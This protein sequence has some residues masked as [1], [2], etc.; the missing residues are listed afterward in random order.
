MSAAVLDLPESPDTRLV[1][2]VGGSTL[3]VMECGLDG[4]ALRTERYARP[5]ERFADLSAG[6]EAFLLALSHRPAVGVVGA[7]GPIIG[8]RAVRLTNV[9]T[10]PEFRVTEAR[11][12]LGI[13]FHLYNDLV[14]AA[15]AVPVL[16]AGDLELMREGAPS[17]DGPVLVSTI[18]TGLND[19]LVLPSRLGVDR[20]VACESGHTPF[21]P[22][23]HDEVRLLEWAWGQ[24]GVDFLSYELVLSGG[25]GFRLLYDFVVATSGCRSSAVTESELASGKAAAIAI[26]DAVV[27]GGDP[28]C[29]RVA[30]LFG[31]IAGTFIGSRTVATVA[32]GGVYLVGGV[33]HDAPFM[34]HVISKTP[35]LERFAAQG[36]QTSFVA[37]VPIYRV[38]HANP[39]LVGAAEVARQLRPQ[40]APAGAD[41]LRH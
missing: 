23:D 33:T 22:R 31:A 34:H 17:V 13:D 40:R 26:S 14:V 19:A 1:V 2:D 28:A 38:T 20:Y 35:F 9:P 18:S 39:G 30:E 10:W 36:A 8:G 15:A 6:L 24:R 37:P 32:S 41:S 7:A 3:R 27:R 5:A 25:H 16:G 11:Q 21:A 12:R 4:V 29:D